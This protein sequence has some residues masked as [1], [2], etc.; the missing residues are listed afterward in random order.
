LN[1]PSPF[2]LH[3]RREPSTVFICTL[4]RTTSA[5]SFYLFEFMI[6]SMIFLILFLMLGLG[7]SRNYRAFGASLQ[8]WRFFWGRI[9]RAGMKISGFLDTPSVVLCWSFY[10]LWFILHIYFE[11]VSG[12][13]IK[14]LNENLEFFIGMW[15]LIPFY[16]VEILECLF[17]AS[18]YE[19]PTI[20]SLF[21]LA[22]TAVN[23]TWK[24]NIWAT[25]RAALSSYLGSKKD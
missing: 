1:Q 6:W 9:L 11:V 14:K 16:F 8:I 21:Y 15:S 4:Q 20:D 2:A 13:W 19:K 3:T 17:A 5:Y 10:N 24:T 23:S 7:V 18:A 25:Y 12:S 22:R